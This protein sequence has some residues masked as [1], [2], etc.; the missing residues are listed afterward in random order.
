MVLH[1]EDLVLTNLLNIVLCSCA[2]GHTYY[3]LEEC[4]YVLLTS[5]VLSVETLS[6]FCIRVLHPRIIDCEPW[7]LVSCF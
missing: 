1:S 5:F 6:E 2:S 7:E 4:A 3:W